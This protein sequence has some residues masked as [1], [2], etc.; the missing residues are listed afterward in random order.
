MA[1]P[2]LV[3]MEELSSG[4]F[5]I[6]G[7]CW[8]GQHGQDES[9]RVLLA[10]GLLV[11]LEDILRDPAGRELLTTLLMT[12]RDQI[13]TVVD[14]LDGCSL[15]SA[16]QFECTTDPEFH[17]ITHPRG[18]RD[19]RGD[20]VSIAVTTAELIGQDGL[21]NNAGRILRDVR[22]KGLEGERAVSARRLE[23]LKA[24]ERAMWGVGVFPDEESL[25]AQ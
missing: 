4:T 9:A 1:W 24:F 5:A 25:T 18:S 10:G 6:D 12:D 21:S 16:T 19:S 13:D 23:D 14:T 20:A 2:G 3:E 22:L 15:Y 17:A 7:L 11:P 8:I